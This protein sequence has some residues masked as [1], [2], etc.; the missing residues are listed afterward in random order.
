MR[1][2]KL[3]FLLPV[4]LIIL[5]LICYGLPLPSAFP[6][7]WTSGRSLAA[8][9]I[10]ALFGFSGLIWLLVSIVRGVKLSG[11]IMDDPL[12]ALGLDLETTRLFY[13]RYRGLVHG[14]AVDLIIRPAYR[15]EPWRIEITLKANAGIILAIGNRRPLLA[16]KG[17]SRINFSAA[18]FS[19]FSISAADHDQAVNFLSDLQTIDVFNRFIESLRGTTGW[20]IYLE[21]LRLRANIRAYQFT[22]DQVSAWVFSLTALTEIPSTLKK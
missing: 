10:T 5:A 21:P 6:P 15:L 22:A 12:A 9:I 19:T 7:P 11:A 13:R 8:A 2:A 17:S 14:R 3:L 20:E 1:V 4:G 16:G 18:P